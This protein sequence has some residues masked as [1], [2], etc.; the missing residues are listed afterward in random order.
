MGQLKGL[1]CQGRRVGL[2]QW[3]LTPS[4][5]GQG[6]GAGRHSQGASIG[7]DGKESSALPWTP[8]RSLRDQALGQHEWQQD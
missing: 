1:E 5:E 7:G 4:R 3:L 8:L 6:S 2:M